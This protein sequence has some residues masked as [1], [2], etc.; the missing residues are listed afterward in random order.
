[1]LVTSSW[2]CWRPFQISRPYQRPV[3]T[4]HQCGTV[5]FFQPMRLWLYFWNV[6]DCIFSLNVK[7]VPFSP[8]VSNLCV[9][10][11]VLMVIFLLTTDKENSNLFNNVKV[12]L[13]HCTY[14]DVVSFSHFTTKSVI[15]KNVNTTSIFSV[16]AFCCRQ[17]LR[18]GLYY[19]LNSV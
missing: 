5:Y 19:F 15:F 3:S 4:M 11:C 7:L 10:Y 13:C 6:A 18:F 1:M 14:I 12:S 9:L 16:L 2:Y 8:Q 17:K